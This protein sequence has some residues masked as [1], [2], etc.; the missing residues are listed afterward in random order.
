MRAI[1]DTAGDILYK[2]FYI[3]GLTELLGSENVQFSSSPFT[4]TPYTLRND[5]VMN[6]VVQEG[7]S[8]KRYTIACND[9][10]AVIPEL[11]EWCDVYGSV[12]ANRALAEERFRSKL[13]ALCPSFGVR[14]A[15][16]ATL[17][18]HALRCLPLQPTRWKKHLGKYRRLLKR[19]AY[20]QYTPGGEVDSHYLFTCSTLWYNDEWNRNDENVNLDRA[21]FI[22]ACRS[23]ED[24]TLEGGLVSQGAGRSSEELFRDCLCQ[25]YSTDQWIA[26]TRKSVC[27]FNTPAFW[28]CHGWKLG[29]YMALGKAIVSTPLFNDLPEPLVSGTHYHLTDRS[30]DS[31][32]DTVHHL[33][34][35]PEYR[36][37]LEHN[38]TDYWQ[39]YGTPLAS[40]ALLGI[41]R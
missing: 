36:R 37:H 15:P 32:R 22:R 27:V 11:Y 31:L 12:N 23:I 41:T 25:P 40:L 34:L 3:L 2:S 18:G 30:F 8:E 28:Q 21:T 1:I 19:K 20:S 13:V 14:Y 24:L 39:R 16:V 9:H 10:H 29:E 4:E 26:L 17:A 35:H 38:I 7:V 6:F 33:M 5:K